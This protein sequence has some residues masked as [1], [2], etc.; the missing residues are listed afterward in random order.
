[1]SQAEVHVGVSLPTL[2]V[3][4]AAPGRPG[5]FSLYIFFVLACAIIKASF[6]D[7]KTFLWLSCTH[8][9][10]KLQASSFEFFD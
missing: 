10:E 4:F 3:Y 2:V 9:K 5:F 7:F 6:R 1:M 8:F